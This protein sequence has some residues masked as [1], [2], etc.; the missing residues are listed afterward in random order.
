MVKTPVGLLL[1]RCF[2]MLN[3]GNTA[4]CY[5]KCRTLALSAKIQYNIYSKRITF[6]YIVILCRKVGD[7]VVFNRTFSTEF[8]NCF[9]G[10]IILDKT[11]ETK[12]DVKHKVYKEDLID[13]LGDPFIV[14]VKPKQK[15]T[16]PI[17][18]KKSSGKVHEIY[19]ET[20]AGRVVFIVGRLFQDGNLYI[21][22][23]YWADAELEKFY[24]Q[25]SKV[26]R[27]E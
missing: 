12:L 15:S 4:K 3:C 19:C 23:A 11:I 25:E 22:T 24:R 13:A 14:V 20:E 16:T 21:I 17:T 9:N 10:T 7:R 18:K 8:I 26:Q 5:A 1:C 2:C 27:N 6:A